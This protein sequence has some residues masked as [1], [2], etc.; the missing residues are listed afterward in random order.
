MVGGSGMLGCALVPHL[1]S[2]GFSVTSC[3][4]RARR[5]GVSVDFVNSRAAYDFLQKTKPG[6]IVNLAALTN[7]DQCEE[8]PNQA[9]LMNV[10]IVENIVA[11]IQ[12]WHQ[13]CHLVQISTDQNYDADESSSEEELVLLNYYGFSKYAGELAARNVGAS[14]L[15]TNFF[16]KSECPGRQSFSDWIVA[17]LLASRQ[18]TVFDDVRFSPLSIPRLVQFIGL[19]ILGRL[20]GTYNVGSRAGMSKADFALTLASVLGFSSEGIVVGSSGDS[21]LVAK[22]PH[23]MQMNCGKIE[24]VLGLQMPTL[25]DEIA[26]MGGEYAFRR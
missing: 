25:A 19:V 1:R 20:N 14:I 5:S 12:E 3:G 23:N 6:V 9:Y 15:R 17:S 18:I 11:W 26:S 13:S 8:Q 21:P 22:R 4:N 16:G 10:K 24:R 7:V 2:L